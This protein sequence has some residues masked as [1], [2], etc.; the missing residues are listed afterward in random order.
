MDEKH[1]I[2]RGATP[3]RPPQPRRWRPKPFLIIG[4]LLCVALL[5]LRPL[6]TSRFSLHSKQCHQARL[7]YA[8][9][10]ISWEAC[11]DLNGRPLECSSID[12]PM[13]QFNADNL[14]NKTF[15]V[16]LIRTRGKNATQ[17]I[18]LNPGGPGGS[19]INFMY[20]LGDSVLSEKCCC[21]PP[22]SR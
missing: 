15:S 3:V 8:G 9:E 11:G 1:F 18:L 22:Q 20:R 10:R 16:P 19:G 2:T 7:H 13:D 5:H 21:P 4:V 17:N 14:G 12:V 6:P